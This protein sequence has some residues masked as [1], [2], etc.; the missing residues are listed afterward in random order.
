M[1]TVTL[2][3]NGTFDSGAIAVDDD[4]DWVEVCR[5]HANG[6]RVSVRL[7]VGA[8]GRV[9]HWAVAVAAVRDGDLA[10]VGGRSGLIAGTI[11]RALAMFG[12]WVDP[13]KHWGSILDA[14]G[15]AY[16]DLPAG[17]ADYA[18]LAALEAG[19]PDSTLRVRGT[20]FPRH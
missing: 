14:S 16:L 9:A 17:P 12:E 7:D 11:P 2:E 6:G 10:I 13:D 5:I 8:A 4:A 1:L 19:D 3:P 20:V 18:I 15:V